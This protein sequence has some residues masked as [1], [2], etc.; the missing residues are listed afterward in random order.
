ML[1]GG[2]ECGGDR[3]CDASRCLKEL[4]NSRRW[5]WWIF[6]V[7]GRAGAAW[8]AHLVRR[9]RVEEDGLWESF[10]SRLSAFWNLRS[11]V[12]KSCRHLPKEETC[13]YF[14]P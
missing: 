4:L 9:W 5:W 12:E 1:Y 14:V 6:A 11:P 8:A 7:V 2:A 10:L 3:D 13:R